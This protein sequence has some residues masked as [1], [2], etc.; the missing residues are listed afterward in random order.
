MSFGGNNFCHGWCPRRYTTQKSQGENDTVTPFEYQVHGLESDMIAERG[1][2][3]RVDEDAAYS[4]NIA[5]LKEVNRFFNKIPFH[6]SER[7]ESNFIHHRFQG[8]EKTSS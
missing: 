8:I 2:D 7:V 1:P 4:I 6:H 3:D 5:P